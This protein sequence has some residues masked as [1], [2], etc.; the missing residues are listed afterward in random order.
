MTGTAEEIQSISPE[1]IRQLP[2]DEYDR[3]LQAR[4]LEAE[5]KHRQHTRVSNT[6]LVVFL[7]GVALAWL[8]FR[9]ELLSAAWLLIPL[10]IFLVLIAL[11]NRVI[12]EKERAERAVAF[13]S[14]GL[15]R[16]SHQWIGKGKKGVRFSDLS[17][18]YAADLDLF[19]EGTL[20]E[21][22][23]TA[24]TVAGEETLASWLK[25]PATVE[26]VRARQ[27][28]VDELRHRLD[29]R[30]DLAV[31]G[32]DV[33]SGVHPEVL[34]RWGQAAPVFR[35]PAARVLAFL[36]TSLVLVTLVSWIV[37]L[38]RPGPFLVALLIQ[39]GFVALHRSK[40]KK[41]I[42]ELE[43]PGREL[44]LFS[45]ILARLEKERFTSPL[46]KE[47]RTSLDTDGLPPSRQ[48]RTLSLL[49][50]CLDWRR[51]MF[52]VP[53]AALLMW[54]T[55]LAFAIDR[56]RVATGA[57]IPRWLQVVGEFEALCAL[58]S[59]AYEHPADPFPQV[60]EGEVCFEAEG[61]GHP[62]IPEEKC[63]RNDLRFGQKLR[64]LVVSGSNMSGKTTLLRTIGINTVLALAG[65]PI[66]A[67]ELRLSP[68]AVG[69]CIQLRDSIQAGHS[70]F[71][72]E[73][74]RIRQM[75]NLTADTLPLLF[76]LDEILHGTNSHDRRIGAEAVVRGLVER[77]AIGLV[78]THDLAL[79]RIADAM[80]PRA[81]N[82]HFQDQLEN[83]RMTFDYRIY[84]GVVEK[85]N[86]LDLMRAV[87]LEV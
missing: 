11:H 25:S 47:L 26:G 70:R 49:S 76:L 77:G 82:I 64:L 33:R 39:A 62:L 54:V 65:A 5:Q 61:I 51:N 28:A 79:S 52:F 72:A 14:L 40:V 12:R 74:L 86:A 53:I 68:L 48:I 73:I 71:Y 43:H 21:L 66:R 87:G 35:S 16:L 78:T 4:R 13:Y 50:D 30:E 20:F 55:H 34:T 60:V 32:E 80:A 81:S 10:V 8:A 31:L 57:A 59:Y 36:F 15:D 46:L 56:W 37:G 83:G 7:I 85:S 19:G 38:T 69:A 75:V 67:C 44:S 9:S 2:R 58:A 1:E 84:P 22:L 18:P 42:E 17:H 63:Q 23:C 27:I 29:L 24:R 6:R 3:R 41:V 45:T